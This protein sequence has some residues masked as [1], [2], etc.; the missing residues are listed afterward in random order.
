MIKFFPPSSS[1]CSPPLFDSLLFPTIW[2]RQCK[3]KYVFS[4]ARR[5]LV[6]V[7][8]VVVASAPVLFKFLRAEG[9]SVF[10]SSLVPPFGN[11]Y[12]HRRSTDWLRNEKVTRSSCQWFRKYIFIFRNDGYQGSL[13]F[14]RDYQVFIRL[15]RR[16]LETWDRQLWHG[17]TSLELGLNRRKDK[18]NPLEGGGKKEVLI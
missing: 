13:S 7:V 4:L 5:R 16:K 6:V 17:S 2:A 9:P 15:K 3:C 12:Q 14:S 18:L 10:S 8:V 1:T 11:Y